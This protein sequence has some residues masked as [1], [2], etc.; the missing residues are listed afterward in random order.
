[1]PTELNRREWAIVRQSLSERESV[2]RK[3]GSRPRRLF[4]QQFIT[5]EKT[6]LEKYR[7]IFREIMSQY[8]QQGIYLNTTDG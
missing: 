4:S 1:M 8:Q 5:D 3:P 6:K 7:T 2:P